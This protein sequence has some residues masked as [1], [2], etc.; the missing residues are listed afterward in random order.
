MLSTSHVHPLSPPLSSAS[1]PFD[2]AP[3]ADD[4]QDSASDNESPTTSTKPLFPPS[5]P[6]LRNGQDPISSSS[7]AHDAP[8]GLGFPSMSASNFGDPMQ[9]DTAQSP[10]PTH[11]SFPRP[12]HLL[13][14]ATLAALPI[15]H[16]VAL[17]QS[18]SR[19][20]ALAHVDLAARLKELEALERLAGVKGASPGEI[21][22]VKVR[23]RSQEQSQK[24][25]EEED[26]GRN[27]L[28]RKEKDSRIGQQWTI[29]LDGP[30][31][32][33]NPQVEVDLDIEDLTEAISSNAFD[34][35]T[36]PVL[37]SEEARLRDRAF[38]LNEVP[39][40]D[41][42]DRASI[43][44][45]RTNPSVQSAPVLSAQPS[46]STLKPAR[47]RHASLSARF[48]GSIS[49]STLLPAPESSSS[50]LPHSP[51]A[52][53]LQTSISND[54]SLVPDLVQRNGRSGSIRSVSSARSTSSR[55]SDAGSD[56][57][58]KTGYSDWFGWKGWNSTSK[59]STGL[60]A[61][62]SPDGVPEE[63]DDVIANN[64]IQGGEGKPEDLTTPVPDRSIEYFEG[65]ADDDPSTPTSRRRRTLSDAS[66][67]LVETSSPAQTSSGQSSSS[68]RT[69]ATRST[70]PSTIE[71]SSS[72]LSSTLS[73]PAMSTPDGK[74]SPPGM[75]PPDSPST[76]R[77]RSPAPPPSL[78]TR[79]A[80]LTPA[81]S[82][83]MTTSTLSTPSVS[84]PRRPLATNSPQGSQI[85][86]S[87][88]KQPEAHSDSA[89]RNSV[90]SNRGS[91]SGDEEDDM[92][93][94]ST[95]KARTTRTGSVPATFVPGIPIYS[96]PPNG[97]AARTSDQGYVAVAKGTIGRAL[98]L[99]L[100]GEPPASAGMTRSQ[101]DGL[102]RASNDSSTFARLP[103]LS[104]SRYSLFSPP[105]T[106]TGATSA[107]LVTNH[108]PAIVHS[109]TFAPAPPSGT[110]TTMELDTISVEAAPPS[111]AL[112]KPTSTTS[113]AE[114]TTAEEDAADD[115]PLIDRYGFIYDVHSGME[116]LKETRRREKE[117]E[118]AYD[119]SAKGR[120]KNR[121]GKG[122]MAKQ[123]EVA[124]STAAVEPSGIATPTQL[125]VHPQ[126]DAIR[127]AMGLT[128]T[129]EAPN[130]F[131][132][133]LSPGES[134]SL[135]LDL[136]APP[137]PPPQP[138]KLVRAPASDDSCLSRASGPQ[139]MRALL[140]QLRSMSDTVERTQQTEW[141]A[142][143][144]KRQ[145]KLAKLKLQQQVNAAHE[146]TS[147]SGK[148]KGKQKKERPKTI[149]GANALAE[150]KVE[151][152]DGARE[153][154]WT[155]NL[156]GVAQMGTEGK[157]KK[158][159][160][161]EFKELVRKGIPIS[162]RP[163]IWGECS[164]A[165]EA[166]EP[167]VYQDLLFSPRDD[168]QS[169]L[170][171][172]DMD[173][174]RTFPTNV[175]FAGNGPGVAK[176]RNVLVAYSRRNPKI[177]YCQGMNNLV[178]TL[179]LTHPAEEDAFW[180]LVC[181][182]ENIL[183]SDYYTSH[184]LVSR[185]DQQVLSDLVSRILPSIAGHL[186]EHGVEL[187]AISFGWFLSLFTDVLPIQTLLRV[188]D[189]FFI[190][191]TVLLFRVAL[192]ILKLHEA[193]LLACDSA[194]GLYGL[195]GSLPGHIY[196]AD[197]LLKVACEDLASSVKDREVAT[198]RRSHVA[199]LQ[200][201]LG[202]ATADAD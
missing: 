139:S 17:T 2:F 45:T 114:P 5:P 46:S 156:V 30:A 59:G 65:A 111:L 98:G 187:S 143:I 84:S 27:T 105:T 60:K 173:C 83:P 110:P 6:E 132:P 63:G 18:M 194:A 119:K 90:R 76:S 113:P 19:D 77:T 157:S 123:A 153:E 78:A 31:P 122:G 47:G 199:A 158:E 64:D 159:D 131:S 100:T 20:L 179:L 11:L 198:L 141:D 180:V 155:E 130:V 40:N 152:S 103:S 22:R 200:D 73:P 4:L 140:G 21:E 197:R 106:G 25:E 149:W 164:S 95:L 162:Y 135:E 80:I 15:S 166:R 42:F 108:S 54:P 128:P 147:S 55:T 97:T 133:P 56:S 101:S 189:L 68:R 191:G 37:D 138:P 58:R 192:S 150:E 91:G 39:S 69:S 38:S 160:W 146:S 129:A 14:S 82:T 102:S 107:S 190:H 9:G 104:L 115:G 176:L 23:S 126:L 8:I 7:P 99:G 117:K 171:Q 185:A 112:H 178:A 44:S 120:Q 87:S 49:G 89:R 96:A 79:Q 86:G 144:R 93:G 10:P 124:P 196:H 67:S 1:L 70:I 201:E 48:F 193:E 174:H 161:N 170:K 16:L 167:G 61:G 177:G 50:S 28:K 118:G 148:G 195:L 29:K 36:S 169:C 168:E 53:S 136:E 183:P 134:K 66:R 32:P 116:L 165:N 62:L 12:P 33:E 35:A 24:E 88:T 72:S 145:A 154:G 181:I 92:D 13:P 184:L 121:G 186:E 85:I 74:R 41:V 151:D 137:R 142:F 202:V 43:S 71:D 81:L 26:T 109:T 34:I 127:E 94:Q 188:W 175:F 163:K 182:V 51:S 3:T 52:P 125:E 172:I 75:T 57:S